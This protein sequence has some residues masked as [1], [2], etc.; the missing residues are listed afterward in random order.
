MREGGGGRER[1]RASEREREREREREQDTWDPARSCWT[2]IMLH[3][4][5]MLVEIQIWTGV[6]TTRHS[7]RS[8]GA[9]GVSPSRSRSVAAAAA[10]VPAA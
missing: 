3:S 5:Q 4:M 2:V 1:D 10:A 8:A 9:G 6:S 7:G